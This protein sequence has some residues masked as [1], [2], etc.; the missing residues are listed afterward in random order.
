[1]IFQVPPSYKHL[2]V[3]GCLCYAHIPISNRQHK[4]SPRA[5]QCVF[6]G[7]PFGQKGYRVYDINTRRIYTSRNVVFIEN[8]FPLALTQKDQP[9][10]IVIP[11]PV[12]DVT[13]SSNIISNETELFV[14]QTQ[15]PED[16]STS[17]CH[18]DLPN[19]RPQRLRNP[20]AYLRDYICPT[21]CQVSASGSPLLHSPLQVRIIL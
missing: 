11:H 15:P 18:P 3:F 6:V 13:N 10:D 4:F 5:S 8:T 20:P 12:L 9:S 21:L 16:T 19:D 14:H 17:E 2:R 7:Y 1:M